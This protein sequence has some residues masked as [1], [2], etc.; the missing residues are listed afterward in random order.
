MDEIIKEYGIINVSMNHYIKIEPEIK[1]FNE[2]KEFYFINVDKKT[3]KITGKTNGEYY[4]EMR[5][6]SFNKLIYDNIKPMME[7]IFLKKCKTNWES[8]IMDILFNDEIQDN[9]I[10]DTKTKILKIMEN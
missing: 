8:N 6:E 2:I 4:L 10:R 7:L 5:M 9:I 3:K 1:K